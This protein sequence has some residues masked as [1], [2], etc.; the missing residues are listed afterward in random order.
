MLISPRILLDAMGGFS[1]SNYLSLFKSLDERRLEELI[2]STTP[3]DWGQPGEL[4]MRDFL[5]QNIR[6]RHGYSALPSH[7]ALYAA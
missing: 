7:A 3:E 6:V 4:T 2:R 1:E 5:A